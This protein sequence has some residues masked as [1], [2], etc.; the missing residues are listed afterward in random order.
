[1]GVPLWLAVGTLVFV[2]VLMVIQG[3]DIHQTRT[4]DPTLRKIQK[5]PTSW[6]ADK[7]NK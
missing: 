4:E 1:M 5:R 2:V 3:K 6:D 7:R